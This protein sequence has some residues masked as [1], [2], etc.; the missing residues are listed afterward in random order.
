MKVSMQCATS[1]LCA[2]C[3][4]AK[5]GGR[6][7][8]RSRDMP[9]RNHATEPPQRTVDD[10][11]SA[12]SH[13]APKTTINHVEAFYS[14]KARVWRR[15]EVKEEAP[16]STGTNLSAAASHGVEGPSTVTNYGANDILSF[17]C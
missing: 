16:W 3:A 17:S 13:A 14:D 1:S 9:G 6:A 11:R 7:M 10:D 12:Q 8:F 5:N 15:Q 2:D 4:Q